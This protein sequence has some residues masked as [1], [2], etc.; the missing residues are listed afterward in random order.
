[1]SSNAHFLGLYA[2]WAIAALSLLY[3]A[4]LS[5][6]LL[7]LSTPGQPIQ[8]PWFTGMELLI[9]VLAPCMVAF[10]A[11]LLDGAA[12]E[13]R[14][15]ALV[16]LVF[17]SMTA[18]LTSAVHF[19]VLTLSRDP[20]FAQSPWAGLV[21]SFTWPSIAYV[22][23]ILAWDLFF[24]IAALCAATALRGRPMLGTARRL[25]IASALLAF[26]GL[27]GVPLA[28]MQVRNIGIVGYAVCY[29]LAAA[30]LAYRAGIRNGLSDGAGASTGNEP[31]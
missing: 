27:A 6:G 16:S 1:M 25:L 14:S 10:S 21:L 4:A 17:M 19:S 9:L 8:D 26:V 28:N 12:P 11:A 3:L 2:G 7:A 18:A 31:R 29:P 23:D 30:V 20:A 24:P 5:F 22:L 15:F 13:Q